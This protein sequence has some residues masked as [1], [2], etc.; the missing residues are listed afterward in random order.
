[1]SARVLFMS[2]HCVGLTFT[3]DLYACG[4][5]IVGPSHIRTLLGSIPPYWEPMKK[6]LV[7]RVGD[8]ENDEALNQRCV[9]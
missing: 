7:D 8:A 4:V 5:D 6:L 2:S 9:H 3:P 1:M